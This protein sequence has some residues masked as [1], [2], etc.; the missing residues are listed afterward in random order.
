MGI[1][2]E[3]VRAVVEWDLGGGSRLKLPGSKRGD[4]GG[5]LGSEEVCFGGRGLLKAGGMS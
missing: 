2:D 5:R 1:E 3:A 4:L